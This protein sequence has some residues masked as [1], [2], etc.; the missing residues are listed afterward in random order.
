[1]P[2]VPPGDDTGLYYI[3]VSNLPWNCTWQR[4]KDFARNQDNEG[5]CI[6]VEHTK[7]YAESTCGWI[8]TR[9]KEDFHKALSH[10]QGGMLNGRALCADG[11]NETEWIE[12][13]DL[14]APWLPQHYQEWVSAVGS[15]PQPIS[16]SPVEPYAITPLIYHQ[17]FPTSTTTS[18]ISTTYNNEVGVPQYRRT[19]SIEIPY[20]SSLATAMA[21]M[22]LSPHMPLLELNSVPP[23]PASLSEFPFPLQYNPSL[24]AF[25]LQ[26]PATYN[27]QQPPVMDAHFA[28]Q[29]PYNPSPETMAIVK[30]KVI[31][32]SIPSKASCKELSAFIS[33]TLRSSTLDHSPLEDPLQALDSVQIEKHPDGTQKSHAF[34]VFETYGMAQAVVNLLDGVKFHGKAL[35]VKLA[36]E[37][38][39]SGARPSRGAFE[40]MDATKMSNV[41]KRPLDTKTS[42]R[43][44]SS[45]Y[46][47]SAASLRPSPYD[48]SASYKK[49]HDQ[50]GSSSTA[51]SS[52]IAAVVAAAKI[53]EI[54]PGTPLVVDGSSPLHSS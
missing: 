43:N 44:D 20:N 39:A 14:A 46:T 40:M 8:T 32:T 54:S 30:S 19:H 17:P 45:T 18:T 25:G 23:S 52:S 29:P 11:R 26:A 48:A 51:V 35:K 4:L 2:Q 33:S 3:L 27:M 36:K 34:L 1:M 13:R 49:A 6:A 37:G 50:T 38:T 10:L 42:G 31:F 9:G 15:T 5:N 28:P 16:I 47:R 12:V 53:R 21:A 24:A 22:T 41:L 7:V